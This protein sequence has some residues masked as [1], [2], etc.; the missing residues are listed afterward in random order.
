MG[1]VDELARFADAAREFCHWAI[2]AD[3]SEPNVRDA[4]RHVLRVYAT[5][6]ELPDPFSDEL[7]DDDADIEPDHMDQVAARASQLPLSIYF[8]VFDPTEDP[9]Q[10]PVTGHVVDDLCDIYRDLARGLMFFNAGD[11]AE[12][13]W[14][15]GFNFR[16]HWGQ[17]ATSAIRALHAYLATQ[18]PSG[19]S[20][21]G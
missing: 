2:G 5:A 18:N 3:G 15:W 1:G 4:L 8:E 19:L 7:S 10:T 16:I 17:H 14:E 13:L 11:P 6:L 20:P 9:P 21:D 12:A